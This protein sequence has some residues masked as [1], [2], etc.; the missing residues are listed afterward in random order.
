[1]YRGR[2]S[3]LAGWCRFSKWIHQASCIPHQV[4]QVCCSPEVVACEGGKFESKVEGNGVGKYFTHNQFFASNKLVLISFTNFVYF[5]FSWKLVLLYSSTGKN[6][7]CD[8]FWQLFF[9]ASGFQNNLEQNLFLECI[10]WKG[11]SCD[12]RNKA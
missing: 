5:N 9:V 1:M 6:I 12:M 3:K 11:H 10:R 8:L 2:F 4:D 7:F